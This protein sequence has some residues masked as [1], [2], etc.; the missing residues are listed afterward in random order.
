MTGAERIETLDVLRGF[1]A[2]LDDEARRDAVAELADEVVRT[3]EAGDPP[4]RARGEVAAA[5]VIDGEQATSQV[6]LNAFVELGLQEVA[7]D[8]LVF[9]NLTRSRPAA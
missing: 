3:F 4:E 9:V 2:R 6:L 8:A 5:G 7:G 1:A